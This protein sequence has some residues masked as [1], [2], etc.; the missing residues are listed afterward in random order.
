MEYWSGGVLGSG[1][2]Y[3]ITPTLQYSN[4]LFAFGPNGSG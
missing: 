2:Q 4:Y 3:S 1:S